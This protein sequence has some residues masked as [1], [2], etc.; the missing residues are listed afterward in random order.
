[1]T[2]QQRIDDEKQKVLEMLEI[3]QTREVTTFNIQMTVTM[4]RG[5]FTQVYLKYFGSIFIY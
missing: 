4:G 1:M 2:K 3:M 5:V